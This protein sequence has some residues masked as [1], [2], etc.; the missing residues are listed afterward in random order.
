MVITVV[1]SPL[2]TLFSERMDEGRRVGGGVRPRGEEV[3]RAVGNVEQAQWAV[4]Q[5]EERQ[6]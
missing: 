4:S 6:V 5:R 2:L 3:R 1:G